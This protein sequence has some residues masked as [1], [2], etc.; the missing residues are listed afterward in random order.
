LEAKL[1]LFAPATGGYRPSSITGIISSMPFIGQ[2]LKSALNY[3]PAF[4]DMDPTEL[5]TLRTQMNEAIAKHPSLAALKALILWGE[6]EQLLKVDWFPGDKVTVVSGKDHLSVCKPNRG[7]K[8][9]LQFI[10][11]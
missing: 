11:E 9:P 5:S 8:F 4:Q 1:R 10:C 6:N 2:V 7:Y 3:S